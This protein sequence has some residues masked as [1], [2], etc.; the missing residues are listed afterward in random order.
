MLISYLCF[1][2]LL[3]NFFVRRE[4][5][6]LL[7]LYFGDVFSFLCDCCTSLFPVGTSVSLETTNSLLDLLCFYGDGE[8]T[9]ENESEEKEDLEEAE[10][11]KSCWDLFLSFLSSRAYKGDFKVFA[12][13]PFTWQMVWGRSDAVSI[14]YKYS[15]YKNPGLS[16][17]P[18]LSLISG[19]LYWLV[20]LNCV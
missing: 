18:K 13:C 1:T 8:S 7:R 19:T 5:S 9:Q 10:V 11:W 3:E 6:N 17:Q 14:S 12:L 15:S 4:N 16:Y 2:K 20:L